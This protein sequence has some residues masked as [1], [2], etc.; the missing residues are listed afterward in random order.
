METEVFNSHDVILFEEQSE[1]QVISTD[2]PF[3]QANTIQSSLKEVK[4][5][6]VIPVFIKDNEP[7]IS[8]SDFI[9]CTMDVAS[10]VFRGEMILSPSVRLSHPIKG[11]IPTA[12]DKPAKELLEYEK[13][14]YYER[15]A[16]AIELPSISDEIDGNQLSLSIG[17][18]K[19]YSLDNLYNKKGVDEHFKVFIG[20]KN[21]VCT[22]L[23]VW[24]EGF[25]GDLKVKNLE[26]LMACMR[27]LFEN[28]NATTHIQ[29]L[30]KL[31]GY[32]LTEQQFALLIGRCRMY[33]HLPN[34]AK[35]DITPLLLSDTQ[36]GMVVKDFYRDNSFCKGEDGNI[37]LWRLYNLFTGSNK[38][39]YIDTFLD[40]SVNAFQ[41]VDDLRDALDN[42][43][44]NWFLN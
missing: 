19:S 34:P 11:R 30:R 17:G 44:T 42:R 9:Q 16:F 6:H 39:S 7:V 37:N 43:T 28:Y 27:T 31:T 20:F 24:S 1:V 35:N 33:N 41:F 12:K 3:I 10:E 5:K 21:S 15:M 4:S 8:H 40:R 26:Q 29:A 25:V 23:C 14:L 38:S 18:V 13:T 22:N 2:K 32:S 36:L